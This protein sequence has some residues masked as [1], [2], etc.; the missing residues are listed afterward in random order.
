MISICI[1]TFKR[2]NQLESLLKAIVHDIT[3]PPLPIEVVVCDNDANRSAEQIVKTAM[4]GADISIKYFCE[5]EQNISLA[6]NK[7]ILE[8]SGEWLAFID[9]DELPSKGWLTN[10]YDTVTAFKADGAFGPVMH[11]LPDQAD[12]SIKLMGFFPPAQIKTGTT[13]KMQDTACGNALVN[14]KFIK[15]SGLFDKKF[16]LTGGED[17]LL[18]GTLLH[19][20][21]AVFVWCAEAIVYETVALN[22][23][24]K[25]WLKN[26]AFRGGQAYALVEREVL[27]NSKWLLRL[28]F[29]IIRL[30]YLLVT[31]PIIFVISQD[32]YNKNLLC[33]YSKLGQLSSALP[34]RY[35]EYK[36][37]TIN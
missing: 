18:F 7:T 30:L 12:A 17:T 3:R 36:L 19:Q 14:A 6:R 16:G 15:K 11:I 21:S 23:C 28:Q 37:S 31:L 34:W 33:L 25:A 8:A 13:L 32:Y 20:F 10:L 27:G 29:A 5:P 4:E 2:A 9:D 35:Q 22:R 1:A 24:T 26:R